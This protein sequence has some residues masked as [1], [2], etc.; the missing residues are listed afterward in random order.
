[1]AITIDSS[2]IIRQI[3]TDANNV[4]TIDAPL[5][6]GRRF[7]DIES[8]IHGV[9][10]TYVIPAQ[11]SGTDDYKAVVESS[12]A[13]VSTTLSV[14]N[15]LTSTSN[16]YKVGDIILMGAT[17][18]GKVNFDRWVSSVNGDTITLD[19]LETQVATHH[20]T[21]GVTTG[22]ALTGMDNPTRTAT[23]PVVG[24]A[25]SVVTSVAGTFVTSVD[26]ADDGSHTL[27]I[28]H[29]T[30]SDDGGV[31][32]SHTVNS[33]SHN[34]TPNTLVSETIGA[35]TTLTSRNYTPHT[36]STTSVAGPHADASDPIRIVTGSNGTD[37]FVKT[38]GST[39]ANTG[40][41]TS[42]I[43]TGANTTGLSTT[44]QAS[45]DTITS[46]IET[47]ESGAHTHIVTTNTTKN[48]V[49]S[50]DVATSVVTSVSFNFT[51]PG[52]QQNVVTSV[53]SVSKSVV[54]SATLTGTKTFMSTWSASVDTDG[55]LSFTTTSATVEISAATTTISTIGGISS[56]TQSA[57]SASISAPRSAQTYT[58][59]IVST[60][61][62]AE[63]NGSHK[64]GFGHTHAIPSHT[65]SVAAHTHTYDKAT[66][67]TS[68]AAIT[69]LASTNYT[70][71]THENV[72]VAATASDGTTF[73]CITGGSTT[74]VVRS[75]K[76]ST[77]ATTESNPGTNAVYTNITGDITFPTLT[78]PTGSVNAPR[79]SITPAA[80]GSETAIKS[81]TFTSSSFVTGLTTTGNIKTSENKGG[82]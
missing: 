71:H 10:D 17:S 67:G 6:D 62:S 47:I 36:H 80:A 59:E 52:V 19:V 68:G 63:T 78:A 81:I 9:V 30:T 22:S 34:I 12:D 3:Q 70:P 42:G 16:T 33:H 74:N 46:D 76:A 82:K 11:T 65:H 64:H 25:V 20:H 69:S 60:S 7:S 32:H 21:I 24:T 58:S 48:V 53:T 5:W 55:V 28:T 35:Y 77:V 56:G 39:S 13:Q 26:L 40:V 29:P 8:M 45:T 51:A 27:Q 43:T 41:N 4:Y 44:A 37:T 75:L 79:E 31:S 38:L 23:I 1:M 15:T 73:K 49:T 18:D 72:T 61:G 50:V 66:I 14:L 57:G 2:K 54:T